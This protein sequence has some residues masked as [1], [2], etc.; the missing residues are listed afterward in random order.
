MTE[1]QQALL[2]KKTED[3]ILKRYKDE[4]DLYMPNG[5]ND[6]F[7]H[8]EH[9]QDRLVNNYLFD[10][11]HVWDKLDMEH[12]MVI[13]TKTYFEYEKL[14]DKLGIVE[15]YNVIQYSNNF[16]WNKYTPNPS[17]DE[18]NILLSRFDYSGDEYIDIL[19]ESQMCNLCRKDIFDYVK[20]WDKLSYKMKII[21]IDNNI[22]FDPLPYIDELKYVD[23]ELNSCLLN[24][25]CKSQKNIHYDKIWYNLDQ[26]QKMN[27]VI[28][29]E[30][31]VVGDKLDEIISLFVN[32]PGYMVKFIDNNIKI[33]YQKFNIDICTIDSGIKDLVINV[34]KHINVISYEEYL[35]IKGDINQFLDIP[36]KLIAHYPYSIIKI[37]RDDLFG[38]SK[39]YFLLD[40]TSN[41]F[42]KIENF[43]HILREDKLKRLLN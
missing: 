12:K 43:S 32:Y 29:A 30:N 9:I 20:H 26:Y 19:T 24:N 22:Y 27:S 4:I 23:D 41:N 14:W 33:H 2:D 42:K 18:L 8:P 36:F 34:F 11:L 35:K 31:F 5:I 40:F 25:Y 6:F 37:D 13:T 38:V 21:V 17:A 16:D 1:E 3:R 39:G 10:Y 7:N 15:R 28:Y